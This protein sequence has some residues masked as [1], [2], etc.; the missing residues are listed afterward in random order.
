VSFPRDREILHGWCQLMAA[1]VPVLHKAS[2]SVGTSRANS[3]CLLETTSSFVLFLTDMRY[4]KSRL[5]IYITRRRSAMLIRLGACRPP[6]VINSNRGRPFEFATC[7][8]SASSTVATSMNA[9]FSSVPDIRRLS[10]PRAFELCLHV[11]DT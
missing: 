2:Q 3:L 8:C 7:C 11:S 1:L 9:T 5:H 6:C 4:M 10:P